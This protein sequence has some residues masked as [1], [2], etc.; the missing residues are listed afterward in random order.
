MYFY[1]WNQFNQ[2][3][4]ILMNLMTRFTCMYPWLVAEK[5]WCRLK[6]FYPQKSQRLS[7]CLQLKLKKLEGHPLIFWIMRFP[8]RR[9]MS[10]ML[11]AAFVHY[12]INVLK[13]ALPPNMCLLIK[14]LSYYIHHLGSANPKAWGAWNGTNILMAYLEYLKRDH[15]QCY[16]CLP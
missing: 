10:H 2:S 11:R 7:P 5:S 16:L 15:V 12:C 6:L 1:S 9:I 13:A 14:S 4:M 3:Q 8:T